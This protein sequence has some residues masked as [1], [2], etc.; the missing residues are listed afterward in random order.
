MRNKQEN[1]FIMSHAISVIIYIQ[2]IVKIKDNVN[3][4]WYTLNYINLT[5]N[6]TDKIRRKQTL[7]STRVSW[8]WTVCTKRNKAGDSLKSTTDLEC[9]SHH[10]VRDLEYSC[11]YILYKKIISGSVLE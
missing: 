6:R 8:I 7:Q 2:I 11:L 4:K 9:W 5:I 1:V 10:E 3:M